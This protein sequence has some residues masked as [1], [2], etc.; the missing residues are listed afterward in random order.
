[1]DIE[2]PNVVS[3][4]GAKVVDDSERQFV[5]ELAFKVRKFVEDNGQL[6]D[7]AVLCLYGQGQDDGEMSWSAGFHSP[8]PRGRMHAYGLAMA[9][10]SRSLGS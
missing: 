3:I 4:N 8:E 7:L 6:P 2:K 9:I 10:L 1:M 5:E